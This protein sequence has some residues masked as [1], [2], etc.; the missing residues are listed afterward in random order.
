MRVKKLMRKKGTKNVPPKTTPKCGKREGE[1]AMVLRETQTTPEGL[2][3][4]KG[5]VCDKRKREGGEGGK[6][7]A[8]RMGENVRASGKGT[9]N[10]KRMGERD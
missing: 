10:R 8:A 1:T 7:A 3:S 9:V 5:G 4:E 6:E 2:K